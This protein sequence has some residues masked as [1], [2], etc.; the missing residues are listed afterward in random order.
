MRPITLLILLLCLLSLTESQ[1][2]QIS[3]RRDFNEE[4]VE[5]NPFG[6]VI[7]HATAVNSEGGGLHN[8][9]ANLRVPPPPTKAPSRI[10]VHFEN[11]YK[12]ES[13]ELYWLAPDGEEAF[14]TEIAPEGSAPIETTVS[15]AF[16]GRG[17]VTGE[18]MNPRVVSVKLMMYL[19]SNHDLRTACHSSRYLHL[20]LPAKPTNF[21]STSPFTN[22]RKY[23]THY[24]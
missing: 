11:L 7:K 16:L 19:K 21:S 13:I 17:K 8:I 10:S 22:N 18:V 12:N 9:L 5:I 20:H 15:H 3:H 14:M 4:D 24:P 1:E 6:K 2:P 23:F